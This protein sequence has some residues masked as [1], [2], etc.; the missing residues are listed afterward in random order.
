MLNVIS[1]LLNLLTLPLL[2]SILSVL[3]NVSCTLERNANSIIFGCDIILYM[4]PLGLSG[5][6]CYLRIVFPYWFLSGW[7]VYSYKWGVC[8]LSS[9]IVLLS[10][11][12][13]LFHNAGF[14]C[15]GAAVLNAYVH[16]WYAFF[17]DWSLS[18]SLVTIFFYF[19]FKSLWCYTTI[20]TPNFFLFWFIW[21][22][23]FLFFFSILS[24]SVCVCP[25]SEV[26]PFW[27]HRQLCS[28]QM[29]LAMKW[30]DQMPIS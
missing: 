30:W 28:F 22:V 3:K 9:I 12:P 19:F 8:S 6:M 11:H 29:I 7:S 5:L 23:F 13:L 16:N 15:L 25:R 14:M 20:A 4:Y 18:L 10:V 17:L 21:N 1:V 27:W 26:S 2:P 24:V